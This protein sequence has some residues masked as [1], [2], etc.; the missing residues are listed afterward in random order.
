LIDKADIVGWSDG[1]IVGLVMS[2]KFSEAVNKFVCVGANSHICG[3]NYKTFNEV[4]NQTLNNMP[5]EIV[6]LLKQTSPE[7]ADFYPNFFEKLHKL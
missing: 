2:L 6:N 7:G 1:G 5:Q 3:T 4:K